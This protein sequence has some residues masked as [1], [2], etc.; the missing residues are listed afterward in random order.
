MAKKKQPK[1]RVVEAEVVEDDDAVDEP[2]TPDDFFAEFQL[3][4]QNMERIADCF[5]SLLGYE[6]D[7]DDDDY[8]PP[9]R[10]RSHNGDLADA[11]L[12]VMGTILEN[13][14]QRRRDAR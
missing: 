12:G 7:D 3:L 10:R 9:A 14:R 4:N 5:E 11:G 8:E 6:H 2:L 13:L 1:E